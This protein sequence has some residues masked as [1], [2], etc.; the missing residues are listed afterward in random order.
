ME[1][2]DFSK[3]KDFSTFHQLNSHIMEIFFKRTDVHYEGER[4]QPGVP[5]G[6]RSEAVGG[7]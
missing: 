4:L 3:R 5:Q 2:D 6:V 7:M 1:W